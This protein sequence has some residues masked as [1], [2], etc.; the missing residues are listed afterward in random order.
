VAASAGAI[1]LALRALAGPALVA[2]ATAPALAA[3]PA[4][5]AAR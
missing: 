5:L 4:A 3:T 1:A 2:S